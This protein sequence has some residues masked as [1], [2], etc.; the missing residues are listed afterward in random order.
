MASYHFAL[1]VPRLCTLAPA[2]VATA[3]LFLFEDFRLTIK[4]LNLAG[5]DRGGLFRTVHVAWDR[6]WPEVAAH[7]LGRPTGAGA[8]PATVIV[9]RLHWVPSLRRA[10]HDLRSSSE[11]VRLPQALGWDDAIGSLGD[12]LLAIQRRQRLEFFNALR[13]SDWL[14]QQVGDRPAARWALAR[15]LAQT[16]EALSL[17]AVA[18]VDEL[19]QRWLDA[20][21]RH[22]QAHAQAGARWQTQLILR[23]WRAS[24][25][26]S[27]PIPDLIARS[28]RAFATRCPG[29]VIVLLPEGALPWQALWC[30]SVASTLTDTVTVVDAQSDTWLARHAWVPAVWPELNPSSDPQRVQS[31]Y[32]RAQPWRSTPTPGLPLPQVQIWR[33]SGL[34]SAAMQAAQWTQSAQARGC[35]QIGLIGLDRLLARRVRALLERANIHL[36]DESGW[37]LST[38]SAA[39]AL[40]RWVDLIGRPVQADRLLDAARSPFL[41]HGWR[42]RDV[43]LDA[44]ERA[45]VGAGIRQGADDILRAVRARPALAAMTL[46][47]AHDEQPPISDAASSGAMPRHLER[48]LSLVLGRLAAWA[49]RDSLSGRLDQLTRDGDAL[50]L[51]HG[52]R[53]DAVGLEVLQAIDALAQDAASADAVGPLALAEFKA[54]LG[55]QLEQASLRE[56]SADC[57][58]RLTSLASARLRPFDAV[59]LLGVG[60]EH[61]PGGIRGQG[62]ISNA[63][64]REL[65]LVTDELERAKMLRDL[66]VLLSSQ[67]SV[68]AIWCHRQGDEPLALSPW[69]ERLSLFLRMATGSE[70]ILEPAPVTRSVPARPLL[71]RAPTAAGRFPRRLSPSAYQDLI[72]CPY[73]FFVRRILR[74]REQD[75]WQLR[76]SKR[77]FG[78]L[79]H[80]VLWDFHR[81]ATPGATAPEEQTRLADLVEQHFAGL[82][83]QQATL[84]AYRERMVALVPGYVAWWMAQQAQ[85]WRWHDGEATWSRQLAL[86]GADA[87]TV[88][89]FDAIEL[90][91]R[92]DRID[93]QHGGAQVRW[94]ILDYKSA[95]RASIRRRVKVAGEDVQLAFYALLAPQGVDEAAYVVFERPRHGKDETEDVVLLVPP[96]EPVPDLAQTLVQHIGQMACA[97]NAGAALPAHGSESVCRHCEAQ[98]L[99]R[100]GHVSPEPSG[101]ESIE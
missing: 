56:G 68:T 77:D 72:D 90:S 37:K 45:L 74:L 92:V 54:L 12:A 1:G 53:A 41:F 30:R 87:A 83:D 49:A 20:V 21:D 78:E 67:T 47:W 28:A 82:I 91:G 34:E 57:A 81:A 15:H 17:A 38:T 13:D 33:C 26:G 9:A 69:F 29:P 8:A 50:R 60:A 23:L 35:R 73:R 95:D 43:V 51:T 19:E 31:L 36:A 42:N 10:L 5:D 55:E 61:L 22:F 98:S 63:V 70:A 71:R 75:E 62:L 64:R 97:I 25:L 18:G 46:E 7:V 66:A 27:E 14:T 48:W 24:L 58:I 99:C 32:E 65:G 89:P 76:A 85:G 93:Q 94:R 79:L 96:S 44:L 59:L 6:W 84:L 52:L 11:P 39:A 16:A 86:R 2:S 88:A 101:V 4:D 100:Y 40:M 3:G 80:A